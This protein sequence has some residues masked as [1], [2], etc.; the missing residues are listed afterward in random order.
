[1]TTQARKKD[2]A[3]PAQQKPASTQTPATEPLDKFTI[4]RPARAQLSPEETRARLETFAAE[5]EEAFVAAV[6]EDA[7]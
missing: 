2:D 3:A 5:R 4:R 6:R 1:M 7:D